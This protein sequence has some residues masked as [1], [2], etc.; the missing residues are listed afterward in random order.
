MEIQRLTPGE[1]ERLKAI[2]LASLRDAPDA[3]GS[4]LEETAVR[5]PES[6]RNQRRA[7]QPPAQVE[8]R[9]AVRGAVDVYRVCHRLVGVAFHGPVQALSL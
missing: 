7:E 5:P 4:T 9:L 2:R 3:F 1:G 8:A 6:W